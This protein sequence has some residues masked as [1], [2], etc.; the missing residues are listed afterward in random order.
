MTSCAPSSTG[1]ATTSTGSTGTSTTTARR[2]S[3]SCNESRPRAWCCSP[4]GGRPFSAGGDFDWFPALQ[5]PG[6][7][8]S[9]RL[10]GKQLVWDLLDVHLPIVCAGSWPATAGPRPDEDDPR[11]VRH[12]RPLRGRRAVASGAPEGAVGRRGAPAG[13]VAHELGPLRRSAQV[14]LTGG[15]SRLRRGSHILRARGDRFAAPTAVY[16]VTE[17]RSWGGDDDDSHSA[18]RGLISASSRS[19]RPCIGHGHRCGDPARRRRHGRVGIG[20]HDPPAHRT[21]REPVDGVCVDRSGQ[22]LL[23]I[24]TDH[25]YRVALGGGPK[26]WVAEVPR[27][28]SSGSLRSPT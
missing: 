28:T 18:T 6:A 4:D 10:D 1:R 24:E 21:G 25:R 12:S 11:R 14:A 15:A 8:E 20:Y 9:L 3:E 2:C 23:R 7:L 13:G 17:R 16:S 5:E 26:P 27:R 19:R 22:D